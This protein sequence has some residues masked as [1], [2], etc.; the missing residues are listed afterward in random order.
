MLEYKRIDLSE[1]IV[2]IKQVLQMNVIFDTIGIL[3]G[4][5]CLFTLLYIISTLFTLVH[6]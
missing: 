2:I 6:C 5:C 4:T 3:K 1:G